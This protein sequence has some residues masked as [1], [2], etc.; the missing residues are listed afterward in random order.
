[1]DDSTAVKIRE[2]VTNLYENSQNLAQTEPLDPV[3]QVP[4]RHTLH[5]QIFVS[6]VVSDLVVG[7][8]ILM[9][10][11]AQTASLKAKAL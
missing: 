2:A 5:H 6:V 9:R 3:I 4:L 10:E 8:D 1:M 11:A 7:D